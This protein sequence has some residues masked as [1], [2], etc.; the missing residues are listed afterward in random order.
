MTR[1]NNKEFEQVC[2]FQSEAS[3]LLPHRDQT[4]VNRLF[5]FYVMSGLQQ[6]PGA[7][8]AFV[9]AMKQTYI[10]LVGHPPPKGVM[11]GLFDIFMGLVVDTD[12]EAPES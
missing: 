8:A 2:Q 5:F 6:H 12:S 9:E 4:A 3:A 7:E 1:Y 10:D 11:I